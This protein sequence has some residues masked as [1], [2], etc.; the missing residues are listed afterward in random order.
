MAESLDAIRDESL[1]KSAP[2]PAIVAECLVV[3]D[4]ADDFEI[5]IMGRIQE[6][7][8]EDLQFD[9]VADRLF[10]GKIL[11]RKPFVHHHYVPIRVHVVFREEPAVK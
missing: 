6:R 5:G 8:V 10:V 4:N 7:A 2:R 11:T 9:L 1:G 3:G